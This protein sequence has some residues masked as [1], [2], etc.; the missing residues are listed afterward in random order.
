MSAY[1]VRRG[2]QAL[3]YPYVVQTDSRGNKH[4]VPDFSRPL[5]F[6]GKVSAE[7][8]QRAE[9]PGQQE[10][11]NVQFMTSEDFT[12]V[13]QHYNPGEVGVWC[14]VEM[15]GLVWDISAPPARHPGPRN[16]T[17]WTLALRE[18]PDRG[19]R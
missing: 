17:H 3:F 11:N 13:A 1:Q 10:V 15:W 18:R 12:R 7:R 19:R 6:R 2:T 16:V 8:S 14:E 9:V 5:E 4:R